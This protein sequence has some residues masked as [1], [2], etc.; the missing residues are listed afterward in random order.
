[1]PDHQTSR[2]RRNRW[3]RQ[4]SLKSD[5]H[6][7]GAAICSRFSEV[8]LDINTNL[9]FKH[10]Y[11]SG[12]T[13]SFPG[14]P[15]AVQRGVISEFGKMEIAAAARDMQ[16]RILWSA[17]YPQIK[18]R[19]LYRPWKRSDSPPSWALFTHPLFAYAMAMNGT[20]DLDGQAIQS[21]ISP[22]PG[23]RFGKIQDLIVGT[24]PLSSRQRSAAQ[25]HCDDLGILLTL[26]DQLP[27]IILSSG[28]GRSLKDIMEL[29][30]SGNVTIDAAVS[31]LVIS[32]AEHDRE[33]GGT[34]IYIKAAQW[35][36]CGEQPEDVDLQHI[37]NFAPKR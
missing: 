10:D 29:A 37:L 21:G 12:T 20:H 23:V 16:R 6:A 2:K 32:D 22:A 35:I 3:G 28:I 27:Q 33:S 30:P 17:L 31:S 26:K 19:E 13:F 4:D 9:A 34:N 25:V 1:M 8:E 24:A 36:L 15:D 14:V 11:L 7:I 5:V 18:D